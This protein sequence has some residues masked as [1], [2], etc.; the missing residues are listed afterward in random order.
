VTRRQ[1]YLVPGFF[2]FSRLGGLNY[3]EG[4]GKV[5]RA[6]LEQKGAEFEIV[7]CCTKPTAS[8]RHRAD[9]LIDEVC[10]NG[11]LEADELHFVGHSTGGLDVRLLCTP[12]VR[13]RSETRTERS[14]VERTRSV[15]TVATPHFGTPLASLFMTLLGRQLLE[16]L[17]ALATSRG[18]RVG[19]LG[20]SQLVGLTQSARQIFGRDRTRILESVT[21]EV[22]SWSTDGEEGIWVYLREIASDQGAM[23]QLMPEATHLFNAAVTDH[24]AIRYSS[25]ATIAPPPPVGYGATDL[26]SPVRVALAGV[27]TLLHNITARE[28]RHYRYP[29][30][31]GSI[32]DQ[33]REALPHPLDA[34]S[35]DG[36]VPTLSQ[37]HGRV[38]DIVVADHLDIVGQFKRDDLPQGDWLPSGSHFDWSR[39]EAA[40]DGV[41][42]EIIM[43][44]TS[45]DL[46]A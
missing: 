38:I 26:F 2:G 22:V 28:H 7:E 39:F 35:N 37:L 18:G 10:K 5:L 31:D 15:I 8:I 34:R 13:L 42:R 27:F 20:A 12:K 14:I 29:Q 19:L 40:W 41:A 1:I 25:L 11:G 24:E 32:L 43:A 3:F 6:A 17:A 23:V 16:V 30:P 44:S 45:Q 46:A 33:Y 9:R 21:K 4:V 36:V